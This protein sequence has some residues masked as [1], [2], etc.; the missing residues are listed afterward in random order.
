MSSFHF[1]VRINS[2]SFPWAVRSV[3]ETDANFRQRPMSD[4]VKQY[5]TVLPV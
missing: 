3:Q 4:I 5:A 2:K 1:S